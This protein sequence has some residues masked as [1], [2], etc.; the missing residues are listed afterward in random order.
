MYFLHF[1]LSTKLETLLNLHRRTL[2]EFNDKIFKF[3]DQFRFKLNS[4][5]LK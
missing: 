1:E 2:T 3:Q 4:S 5:A